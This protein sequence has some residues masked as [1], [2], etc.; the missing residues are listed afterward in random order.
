MDI[1]DNREVSMSCDS[2]VDQV[3]IVR[4]HLKLTWKSKKRSCFKHPSVDQLK[5][6]LSFNNL[7]FEG[8]FY[9]VLRFMEVRE[10]IIKH[11]G[12]NGIERIY[13]NTTFIFLKNTKLFYDFLTFKWSQ[14]ESPRLIEI[15]E[16]YRM[17][18]NETIPEGISKNRILK[19]IGLLEKKR[20]LI[21][22]RDKKGKPI[23]ERNVYT[24]KTK[25]D[26]LK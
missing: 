24:V 20:L 12:K 19:F 6:E 16:D 10:E 17:I 15:W 26:I 4:E 25:E 9:E 3:E 21:L 18:R 23:V 11:M 8:K 1:N 13:K 5:F 7:F 22:S 14:T 2:L